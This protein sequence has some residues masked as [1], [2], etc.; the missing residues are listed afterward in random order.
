M[1]LT[2]VG[3]KFQVTIPKKAREAVGIKIGDL[4][5]ATARRRVIVLRPKVII[6]K[7]FVEERL[8]EAEE[9]IKKGR[10]YGPF[11]SVKEMARSLRKKSKRKASS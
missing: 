10:V 9:D 11:R 4:V 3:P 6:D 8:A 1:A 2:K 5:E 7:T